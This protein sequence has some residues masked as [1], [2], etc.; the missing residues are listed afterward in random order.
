MGQEMLMPRFLTWQVAS[1]AV[2]RILQCVRTTE[3]GDVFS[4]LKR[5]CFHVVVL[6]PSMPDDRPD[7]DDYPNYPLE[8]CILY[9]NSFGKPAWERDYEDIAMCKALQ[10]WQGRNNGACNIQPH[11]LFP[12]DVPFYGGVAREGIVVAC[13]GVQPWFDRMIAG[14]VAD[15]CI[16]IAYDEWEK[17]KEKAE[18]VDSLGDTPMS[19]LKQKGEPTVP[20]DET[21]DKTG[22]D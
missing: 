11:L 16:A 9:E 12:G 1:E 19:P 4:R 8:P 20:A 15:M 3:E 14:M 21:E 6:V 7:Y 2:E 18:D 17:S 22:L 5:R 10:L 13:S